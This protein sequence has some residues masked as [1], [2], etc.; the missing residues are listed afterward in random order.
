MDVTEGALMLAI[1][2]VR[3]G[4]MW[5]EVARAIQRYVEDR[6]LSVVREF[7]GHGI[8][9]EMW[10]EPKVPNYVDRRNIKGD[11]RLVKGMTLAIEPMVNLGEPDVEY[12]GRDRWTVSTKD[13]R[14]AAHYEHTVAVTDNGADVLTDGRQ[15]A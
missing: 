13:R 10:E 5:S 11:F 6:N 9:Q 4:R 1:R 3:A 12:A 8:G 15:P 14:Y 2:E 7:V